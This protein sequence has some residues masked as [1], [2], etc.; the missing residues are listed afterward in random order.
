MGAFSHFEKIINSPVWRQQPTP[1]RNYLCTK[2]HCYSTCGVQHS[3]GR[4]LMLFPMQPILCYKCHH[5]HWS[6]FHLRSEWVQ[7]QETQVLVDDNM[8]KQWEAAKGEKEMTEALVTTSRRAL[9]D[10]GHAMDEAMGE[11]ARLAEDY[12]CLSLSGCFSAPLE[13]ATRLLEQRCR[14][15]EEKGVSPE[16][17]ERMHG[18]LEQMK[19]RLDVLRRAKEKVVVTAAKEVWEGVLK[20]TEPMQ[21]GTR[22]IFGK[23]KEGTIN[24]IVK[25]TDLEVAEIRGVW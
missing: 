3:V 17:L 15:M 18:S 24:A 2:P 13:K 19:E 10:L 5:P 6:H 8:K 4:V 21:E 1:T 7:V 23:V 12:A 9:G 16:Q 25:M 20:A 14:G 22:K 11:L